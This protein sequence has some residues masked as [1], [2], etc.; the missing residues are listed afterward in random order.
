M[1]HS[2]GGGSHSGG[3]HGGSSR[4]S[5]RSSGRSGSRGGSGGRSDHVGTRAFPG[6]SRYVYYSGKKP[7]FFYANYDVRKGSK[8]DLIV[9]ILIVVLF[10]IPL[11]V[12]PFVLSYFAGVN[13]PERL[14]YIY[15]Y[16]CV[17]EDNLDV[18]DNEDELEDVFQDFFDE[19]GI[20]VSVITVPN[21]EWQGKGQTLEQYAYDQYLEH[22]N[23]EY[24][25][26]IVY[27]SAT[28]GDGFDDW[29]W[30]GMQGD[31]T[32]PVLTP[33]LARGFNENF[34]K[35]L[36]QNKYSVG[37]ALAMSFEELTPKMMK[38]TYNYMMIGIIF[39]CFAPFIILVIS[40]AG[41]HPVLS[42]HYKKAIECSTK[43]VDQEACEYCGGVYVVGLH[44]N[45]PHCQA[46]LKKETE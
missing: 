38:A 17:I 34:Q 4:S 19:T 40:M 12:M 5:S 22:F 8:S 36:T 45:C 18:L 21:S 15:N 6:A 42:A 31:N 28:T 41:F 9:K 2:S 39:A 10:V 7:H 23:N 25:W 35:R 27:S 37:Q 30:E 11:T 13:R 3:S 44:T 43:Y 24:Y 26:L 46:L 16:K 1:P 29:H 32:D 14:D 20:A 33:E